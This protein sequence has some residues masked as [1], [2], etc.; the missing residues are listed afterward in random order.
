MTVASTA[1]G[2]VPKRRSMSAVALAIV[3]GF[4]TGFAGWVNRGVV[5]GPVD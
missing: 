1:A 4:P 3:S 5:I 2:A